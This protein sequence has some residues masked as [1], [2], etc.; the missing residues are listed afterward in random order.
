VNVITVDWEKGASGPSYSQ[1]VANTELVGRQTG[2]LLMDMVTLGVRSSNI[3]MVGF[4]LGAHIA[5]C[6]SHILLTRLHVKVGR[7]TGELKTVNSVGY[8]IS[9]LIINNQVL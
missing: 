3:H 4:S 1:A 5:A 8:Q 9:S 6:A 7:I 2:L